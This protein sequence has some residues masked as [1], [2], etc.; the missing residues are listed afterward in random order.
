MPHLVLE[1]GLDGEVVATDLA[2]ERVSRWGRA[3]LKTEGC[4]R[5]VG[6]EALMVEG[7]VVEFSRPQHP[8]AVI[9]WNLDHTTIRLW[10]TVPVERTRPVQRWL[11]ELAGRLQAVG[12]GAVRATNIPDDVWRDLDLKVS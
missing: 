6:R 1:G 9:S 3:V 2:D 4:W 12:A 8:V 11:A 5:R 10:P 7:V